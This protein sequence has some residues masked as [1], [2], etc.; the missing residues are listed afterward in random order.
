MGTLP[1]LP[2]RGGSVDWC[3]TYLD[4]GRLPDFYM[5]DFS[6]MG[7]NVAESAMPLSVCNPAVSACA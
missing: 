7:L 5:A 3:G 6:V 2:K 1:I 4:G